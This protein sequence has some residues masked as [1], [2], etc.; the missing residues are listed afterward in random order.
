MRRS[1][2]SSAKT[3]AIAGLLTVSLVLSESLGDDAKRLP[4]VIAAIAAG[5]IVYGNL[6]ALRQRSYA[7]M[8]AYSGIAQA[9]YALVPVA[10]GQPQQ[11]AFFLATYS[12]AV[13]GAF[14][15]ALAVQRVRPDWDGSI[16][17]MAGLGAHAPWLS[18]GLATLLLSL[19]GIPP[20]LGFWGKL[21]AFG[22]AVYASRR[23]EADGQC[24][25]ALAVIGL[26]GSVV[27]F[28]YYGAVLRAM[29]F[30]TEP[31]DDAASPQIEATCPGRR[32]QRAGG[33]RQ[34]SRAGWPAGSWACARSP[35][36]SAAR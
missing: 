30:E 26:V 34:R 27:S 22:V 23:R 33:A 32:R 1:W 13:V 24:F 36:C 16:K 21:Q 20:L 19:T 7:R 6:A 29:Y 3:G 35:S 4:V 14:L 15:A 17:G 9:G 10:V 28:G 8:L 25:L 12:I 31:Q 11:A 2:P 5:S 18:A